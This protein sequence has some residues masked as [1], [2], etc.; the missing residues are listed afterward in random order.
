MNWFDVSNHFLSSIDHAVR[1]VPLLLATFEYEGTTAFAIPFVSGK[2]P[3]H[4]GDAL[5]GLL[6]S[7][8]D[9][10]TILAMTEI[11]AWKNLELACASSAEFQ[12]VANRLRS[13]RVRPCLQHG[14][15][16]PWNIKVSPRRLDGIGLGKRRAARDVGVGWVHYCIQTAILVRR[17]TTLDLVK[18]AGNLL[19]SDSFK[20]YAFHSS[21]SGFERDLLLGYLFHLV[22]VIQPSEGLGEA[23]ELR[24]EL[25][26]QWAFSKD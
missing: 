18:R 11:S 17:E 15:F 5:A 24:T 13:R 9:G 14:D 19:A 6:N 23:K 20:A 22:E 8:I 25:A 16:V 7:W 4:E 1:A 21:I 10:S 12:R 26:R 2:S 3:K